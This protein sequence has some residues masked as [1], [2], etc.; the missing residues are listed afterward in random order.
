MQITLLWSPAIKQL[1]EKSNIYLYL[2]IDSCTR[3][4]ILPFKTTEAWCNAW[5]S[6]AKR[7][8]VLCGG[9][10]RDVQGDTSLYWNNPY[11]LK[12]KCADKS[13]R[14]GANQLNSQS[15]LEVSGFLSSQ[16]LTQVLNCTYHEQW[17]S[18]LKSPESDTG[19]CMGP[20]VH[21]SPRQHPR[22]QPVN[23]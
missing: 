8:H 7:R 20:Y 13:T 12:L 2:S 14:S 4:V 15:R 18:K 5:H 10:E 16:F 9:W 22:Y 1:A 17:S 19:S 21:W 3:S 11:L 23:L 6:A